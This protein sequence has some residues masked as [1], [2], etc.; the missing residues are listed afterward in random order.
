MT[1]TL[2][3]YWRSSASY[4]VRIALGAKGLA[5][6]YKPVNI[7]AGEHKSPEYVARAPIG[8]VPTLEIDGQSFV[9]SVAIME[10]LEDLKPEPALYPKEPMTRAHVRAMVETINSGTQPLHN[11]VVLN[12]FPEPERKAW[13][14]HFIARGLVAFERLLDAHGDKNGPHCMGGQFTAADV[15]LVPQ[16]YAA[17]RFEVDL[18]P[19]PLCVAADAN[20]RALPFVQAAA[21]EL[22]ADAPKTT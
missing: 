4:R 19:L 14:Q 21:P 7:L 6:T 2:Y 15:L 1:P 20:A 3:G 5:Y 22:Q 12:R 17:R 13:T 11:L 9:E 10:F 8:H 16:M 18:G